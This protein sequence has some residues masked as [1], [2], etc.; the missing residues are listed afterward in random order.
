[1]IGIDTLITAARTHAA[2]GK[3]ADASKSLASVLAES[4]HLSCG[5]CE[6]EA[7]LALAEIEMKQGKKVAA[8]EHFAGLEKD[9]T[10]K[11]FLLIAHEAHAAAT[12]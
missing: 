6:F 11:G 10:S 1:L 5:R 3:A 4:S 7:R 8:H 9:A 2:T 12:K